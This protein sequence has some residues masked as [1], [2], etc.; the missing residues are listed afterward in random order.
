MQM[1]VQMFSEFCISLDNRPVTGLAAPRLQSLLAYLLFHAPAPIPRSCLAG[2]LTPDYSETAARRALSDA[3]YRLKRSLGDGWLRADTETLAFAA[4]DWTFDVREF[5]ELAA[6]AQID[7]RRAAVELYRDDFLRHLD[8]EWMLAPRALL[9]EEFLQLLQTLCADLINAQQFAD[10]L[11]YAHR[12]TLADPLNEHAHRTTMQ[13]YARLGRYAAALQQYA[14]LSQLLDI[15]LDAEP[16]PETRALFETLRAES[17]LARGAPHQRAAFIGRRDERAFLLERLEAAQSGYGGIVLV[18]GEAGIGKTHL[19][20]A[21]A[22]GAQW[23][24]ATVIWGVGRELTGV[25]PFAP[26]DH[27]LASAITLARV[28]QLRAQLDAQTLQ[29]LSGLVPRLRTEPAAYEMLPPLPTA[30]ARAVSALAQGNTH[31]WLF[32]DVQW[33]DAGF[34]QTIQTLAPTLETQRTLV[35]LAYRS[36]ELR[37]N[38][39]A[40]TALQALDRAHALPKLMLGGFSPPECADLARHLGA[41]LDARAA[42]DLQTR[43]G[44]NPLFIHEALAQPDARTATLDTLLTRRLTRLPRDVYA[45]LECA[46]VLGREFTHGVWQSIVGASVLGALPA[47]VYARLV[48]ENAHGYH[49][50]HDLTR[51]HVYRAIPPDRLRELHQHSADALERENAEPGIVAWHYEQAQAWSKALRS[52]RQAGERAAGEYACEAALT[53]FDHALALLSHLEAPEAERLALLLAKQ[54][55]YRVTVQE[56]A[57]RATVD[58]LTEAAIL[59]NDRAALLEALQARISLCVLAADWRG[60]ETT[61]ERALALAQE[62]DDRAAE[63]RVRAEL[64]WHL[65]DILGKPRAALP[66]LQR[67]AALA[68]QLNDVPLLLDI[69]NHLAFVQRI[70]GASAQARA[71][72]ERA[73]ARVDLRAELRR[74]RAYALEILGQVQ[75]DLADFQAAHATMREFVAL[76]SESGAQW[77]LGQGLYNCAMFETRM[78]MYA[79][80]QETVAELEMLLLRAGLGAPADHWMWVEGLNADMLLLAG[81][82]D[83]AEKVLDN[84]RAWMESKD[85]GRP[86]LMG[87]TALGR[88]HLARHRFAQAE[89]VL[90]RAV[91]VWEQSGGTIEFLPL[92]LHALAAHRAGLDDDAH[93]SL[94]RA[95]QV[96]HGTEIATHRVLL[97]FA[98]WDLT[99]DVTA[100]RAAR[101]ELYRQAALFTDDTWRADFL[102]NVALHREIESLYCAH[103]APGSIVRVSLARADAPLGRT[104]AV[105]ER[106]EIEWTLDAPEDAAV[107][108]RA[109]KVALRRHRLA[110]LLHEARAQ[111]AAPTDSDLAR[112]LDVNIRT[113]ERDMKNLRASES[114]RTRRRK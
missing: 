55:V 104:L 6:S 64:G 59:A 100:L 94:Q 41:T 78:G 53:H 45:A 109:G 99:G 17:E 19:L 105:H 95:E 24:G 15:E 25:L 48:Q 88:L 66:H 75:F 87:L 20:N 30:I 114:P 80:A 86:L 52:Y 12:W 96:V 46:A 39:F 85:S 84:M 27:A 65:A 68:E 67:A 110:R 89:A 7:A 57:W 56:R 11:T 58:E 2:L 103:I 82:H 101:D 23:R 5:R 40:W 97:H 31:L 90:S 3:L 70:T 81:R 16:L 9:R 28:E 36:V 108:K 1:R 43:T 38:S 4:N 18:E 51:E 10:A 54:R 98:R 113:V 102:Q 21:L 8:A 32:D 111:H 76:C 112:A 93:A 69:L 106:V 49:F 34:W 47:L 77:A 73:L 42:L 13:L 71:S 35:I 26:L 91:R 63:A 44:G 22:E 61:A 107:L 33:A 79:R 60:M 62:Q 50:Q 14:Q 83:E 29:V 37:A 74:A 92:L 72:A